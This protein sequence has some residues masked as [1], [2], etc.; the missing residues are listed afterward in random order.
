VYFHI[1]WSDSSHPTSCACG[2]GVI[3]W[4]RIIKICRQTLA[5]KTVN[6]RERDS[7][8]QIR[9]SMDQLKGFVREKLDL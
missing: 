7:M 3:D 4:K 1:I 8:K 5:D 6:V 9:I 2:D